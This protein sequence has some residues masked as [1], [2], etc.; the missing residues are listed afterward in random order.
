MK[1]IIKNIKRGNYFE[2]YNELES[3]FYDWNIDNVMRDM[4][5]LGSKDVY[6]FLMYESHIFMY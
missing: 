2:A 1:E 3:L 5:K 6:C 4:K